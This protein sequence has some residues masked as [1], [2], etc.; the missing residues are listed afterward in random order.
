MDTNFV[1][2]KVNRRPRDDDSDEDTQKHKRNGDDLHDDVPKLDKHYLSAPVKGVKQ[3]NH[4]GSSTKPSSEERERRRSLMDMSRAKLLKECTK[5]KIKKSLPSNPG[6][7][8]MVNQ[9][10]QIEFGPKETSKKKRASTPKGVTWKAGRSQ[11]VRG[12]Q[13]SNLKKNRSRR[14]DESLGLSMGNQRATGIFEIIDGLGLDDTDDDPIL[15]R[16]ATIRPKSVPLKSKKKKKSTKSRGDDPE[17]NPYLGRSSTCRPRVRPKK[18]R[19]KT[20]TKSIKNSK[21]V[22]AEDHDDILLDALSVGLKKRDSQHSDSDDSDRNGRTA[23]TA[24]DDEKE[25]ST[26]NAKNKKKKRK[27][28]K[29]KQ[30]D[31]DD[32]S[33]PRSSTFSVRSSPKPRRAQSVPVKEK[34]TAAQK[35]KSKGKKKEK[36]KAKK[37][38]GDDEAEE[39]MSL[40]RSST[41]RPRDSRV[42]CKRDQLKKSRDKPSFRYDENLPQKQNPRM[43]AFMGIFNEDQEEDE[44]EDA[45]INALGSTLK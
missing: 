25:S 42:Q 13:G 16:P 27:S 7:M 36:S 34:K 20:S 31:K 38:R 6:K 21:T 44:Q 24:G 29:K 12:P 32:E 2:L 23:D 5:L 30:D 22:L 35:R 4:S 41:W 17:G 9:L 26:I 1:P 15:S 40:G 10:I 28:K 18:E 33:L 8:E 45:L 3:R 37:G 19:S 14:Y 43:A 39:N 11:T